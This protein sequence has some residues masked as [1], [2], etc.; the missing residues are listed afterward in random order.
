MG[1]P[2]NASDPLYEA[3]E[4]GAWEVNVYPVCEMFPCTEEEF[5]GSWEDRF[6]YKAIKEMYVKA[7]ATGE[8]SSFNQ[9]MMLRIMSEEDRLIQESDLMWFERKLILRNKANFNFFITTDI[10]TSEKQHADY[11]FVSVWALNHQG[12]LYWVDGTCARQT[13]NKPS[14]WPD[15]SIP[16]L[17]GLYMWEKRNRPGIRP[18]TNKLQRFNNV[19]P[20]FKRK[21]IY[22]PSD[23]KGDKAYEELYNEIS[24]ACAGG[25]K[26]KHDD[27]LDT[28]SMLSMMDLFEPSE[29]MMMTDEGGG[30][31]FTNDHY[32]SV[33]SLSSY[34]V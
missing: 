30:I 4:S 9:E 7:M 11:S 27:A 33:N 34:I 1:T 17:I 14:C 21:K 20:L 24:L 31:Y 19:V 12:D 15:T 23:M 26:S 6:T 28:I 13:I 25:F 5:R 32:D 18:N 29:P 2:F 3:V 16:T 22:L 10:A 8:V